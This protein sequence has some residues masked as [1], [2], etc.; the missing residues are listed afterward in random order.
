MKL[1]NLDKEI[2]IISGHWNM[3]FRH[4]I[5]SFLDEKFTI[6][7]KKWVSPFC[8][9][10]CVYGCAGCYVWYGKSFFLK[11]SFITETC[12][13]VLW[14]FRQLLFATYE[15]PF[16]GLYPYIIFSLKTHKSKIGFLNN[17]IDDIFSQTIFHSKL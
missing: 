16:G 1:N 8:F 6:K 17:L 12:W 13:L 11:Y 14:K 9:I 7:S 10:F 2:Y 15:L 4:C 5:T 3:F